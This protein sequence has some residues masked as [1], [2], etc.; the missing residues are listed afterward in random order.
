MPKEKMKLE[1]TKEKKLPEQKVTDGAKPIS[2]EELTGIVGGN[3][4][5]DPNN[6]IQIDLTATSLG[7]SWDH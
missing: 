7:P 6:G 3:G 5:D 2:E 1:E 4:G